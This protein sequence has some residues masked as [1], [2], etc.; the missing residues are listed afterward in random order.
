MGMY[1]L[2]IVPVQN[3]DSTFAYGISIMASSDASITSNEVFQFT[4][5]DT[6]TN[7]TLDVPENTKANYENNIVTW[8]VGTLDTLSK[9]TPLV[10]NV[11]VEHP[12][13][14]Q[15]GTLIASEITNTFLNEQ[16][17]EMIEN[18]DDFIFDPQPH[19]PS[20]KLEID[21]IPRNNCEYQ[22]DFK[23]T[24]TSNV[25]IDNIVLNYQLNA[26]DFEWVTPPASTT[27]WNVG[28]LTTTP[29]NRTKTQSAIIRFIGTTIG[30]KTILPSIT[31]SPPNTQAFTGIRELL[32]AVRETCVKPCCE[33]CPTPKDASFIACQQSKD[34]TVTP[35]L[36]SDGREIKVKIQL[37]AVCRNKK[38]V[39]GLELFAGMPT[40][41]NPVRKTLKVIQLTRETA[42]DG[43]APLEC[44]CATFFIPGPICPEQH[45]FIKAQAHYF[46]DTPSTC[47]CTCPAT[48]GILE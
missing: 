5:N 11:N 25:R 24:N 12:T 21:V 46:D 34:V 32:K 40:D 45:F 33:P 35:T 29:P 31:A 1:F 26:T 15:E 20:F 17:E 2:E 16:G 19:T 13:E 43:C 37:T 48:N 10:L 36:S 30:L 41:P 38:V 18:Y 42:P 4:L 23:V 7:V 39:V 14:L 9:D 6:F 47:S 22:L 3:L 27:Q 8:E 28:T 44:D